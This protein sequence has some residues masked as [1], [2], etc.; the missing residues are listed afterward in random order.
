ML[1]IPYHTQG[2]GLSLLSVIGAIFVIFIKPQIQEIFQRN[3][4]RSFPLVIVR[5]IQNNMARSIQ[6]EADDALRM[7]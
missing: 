1:L 3:Q 2:L 4:Q 6:H 5:V 7:S